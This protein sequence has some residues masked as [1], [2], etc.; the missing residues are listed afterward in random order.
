MNAL[1][2]KITLNDGT[3]ITLPLPITVCMDVAYQTIS[4]KLITAEDIAGYLQVSIKQALQLITNPMFAQLTHNLAMASARHSFDA[5]AFKELINLARFS[6][7]ERIKVQ[8]IKTLG[9][10]LGLNE[11]KKKAPVNI[12]I[13]LDEMVRKSNS[14]PFPGF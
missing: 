1:E 4:G 3:Q 2:Q 10:M 14:N 12:N 5:I 9:D 11:S 6:E 13:S 8:A 7:A